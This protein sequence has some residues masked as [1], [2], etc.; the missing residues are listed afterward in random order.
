MKFNI[1]L[2]AATAAAQSMDVY[3][4]S[5]TTTSE[6]SSYG[7]DGNFEHEDING[8]QVIGEY[9]TVTTTVTT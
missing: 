5:S 2:L 7:F 8:Q 6:T 4:T 9:E 1:A 3:E